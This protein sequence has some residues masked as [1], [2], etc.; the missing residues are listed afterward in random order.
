MSSIQNPRNRTI[1]MAGLMQATYLC[2]NLATF[3]RCDDEQLAHSLKSILRIDADD[4]VDVYGSVNNIAKGLD[5]LKT[6]LTLTDSQRDLDL[7]RYSA[8]LIQLSDNLMQDE[9]STSKL[10][11]AIRKSAQLEFPVDDPTMITNLANI[12]R[13]CVSHLSPRIMISGQPEHLNNEL[14]AAKIR[15]ALLSGIR[16]V[17]LWRQCGGTKPGLLL[18]RAQYLGHA[19]DMLVTRH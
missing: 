1:A 12:Y 18:G 9:L 2:K 17:V 16:A 4:V 13:N 5:V 3:G 14:I 11:D 19:K 10:T 6:Q 15:A 8:S 7:S